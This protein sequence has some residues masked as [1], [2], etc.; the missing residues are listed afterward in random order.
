MNNIFIILDSNAIRINFFMF[1]FKLCKNIDSKNI[2]LNCI[3]KYV[4]INVIYLLIEADF[5]KYRL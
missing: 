2:F 3:M 5:S 1:S 4:I